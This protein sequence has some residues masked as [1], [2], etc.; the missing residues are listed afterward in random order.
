[1]LDC[2]V[3]EMSEALFDS[4]RHHPITPNS[5]SSSSVTR[6]KKPTRACVRGKRKESCWSQNHSPDRR[7][8]SAGPTA[9]INMP[10]WSMDEWQYVEREVVTDPK[11]GSGPW[12]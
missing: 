6:R 1:M 11:G 2:S 8:P 3:F 12:R 5:P 7:S 10:L 9:G 4:V